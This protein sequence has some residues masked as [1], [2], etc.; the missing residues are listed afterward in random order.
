[1]TQYTEIKAL[2][3]ELHAAGQPINL[4]VLIQRV[5]GDKATVLEHY[6]QWRSEDRSAP[7]TNN[8]T[9]TQEPSSGGS[10]TMSDIEFTQEF[11]DAF[12]A[13]TQSIVKQQTQPL[14]EKIEQL[15]AAED[16]ATQNLID[17][18]HQFDALGAK[19]K[20]FIAE[21]EQKQQEIEQQKAALGDTQQQLEQSKQRLNSVSSDYEHTISKLNSRIKEFDVEFANLARERDEIQL[22]NQELSNQQTNLTNEKQQLE[23][24]LQELT[25]KLE[26]QQPLVDKLSKENAVLKEQTAI[27]AEHQTS[28]REDIRQLREQVK[29]LQEQGLELRD[30]KD[31]ALADVEQ[32]HNQ[33][34][35]L[36][37]NSASTIERLTASNEQYQA[38]IKSLEDELAS[39]DAKHQSA[40]EENKRLQEQITFLKQNSSSTLERLSKSATL[41]QSRLGELEQSLADTYAE[42]ERL[43]SEDD[44]EAKKH[45]VES[46]KR[47]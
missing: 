28:Q 22:Q 20:E 32:L 27:A 35:F 36:K 26:E 18:Q 16:I 19:N 45:S 25:A 33:V 42:L 3:D 5:N 2:C 31:K 6:R 40:S 10:I 38:T 13:Q 39:N 11:V 7:K 29:M 24:Q 34:R 8:T 15:E 37:T 4:E 21:L 44:D 1:M 23:G 17:L 46:I 12:K 14:N 30:S 43:R 41:A 9:T 47:A